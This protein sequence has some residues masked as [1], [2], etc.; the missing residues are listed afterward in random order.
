MP[1][2]PDLSC[3]LPADPQEP[4]PPVFCTG[5]TVERDDTSPAIPAGPVLCRD[6]EEFLIMIMKKYQSGI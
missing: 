4:E 1:A 6:Y 5:R 3:M 2:F